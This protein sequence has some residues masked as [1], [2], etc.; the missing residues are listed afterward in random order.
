M[1]LSLKPLTSHISFSGL[2][3]FG[4]DARQVSCA[5]SVDLLSAEV[6]KSTRQGKT[7]Q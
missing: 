5:G 4:L 1:F 7:M 6:P 3:A 2:S